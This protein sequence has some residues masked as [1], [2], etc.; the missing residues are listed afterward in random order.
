M[1]F[2]VTSYNIIFTICSW[3]L[4][5][6]NSADSDAMSMMY[7][8]VYAVMRSI[9]SCAA[10]SQRT[11]PSKVVTKAGCCICFVPGAFYLPSRSALF[12]RCAGSK[13][14]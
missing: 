2:A 5:V 10:S 3:L 7:V 9:V 12:T 1:Q 4:A 8:A 14:C 11:R 6:Y 13:K